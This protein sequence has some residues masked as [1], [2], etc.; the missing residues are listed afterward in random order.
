MLIFRPYLKEV[1]VARS[2]AR[3]GHSLKTRDG[4]VRQHW[5]P[6]SNLLSPNDPLLFF[7]KLLSL[8]DHHF[9]H[10]LSLN[11]P[12]FPKKTLSLNDPC[13]HKYIFGKRSHR[14][15]PIFLHIRQADDVQKWVL[16]CIFSW[17]WL[18]VSV[19]T[20]V[21]YL[22]GFNTPRIIISCFL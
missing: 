15:T 17:F 4:D 19:N 12:H 9:Q 2:W 7:H 20:S 11:D 1:R 14:M 3:G 16:P 13:F 22:I 8:N 21:L 5:P 10:A 6:F 18:Y